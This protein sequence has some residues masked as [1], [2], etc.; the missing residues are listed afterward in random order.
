LRGD[1]DQVY[2]LNLSIG[3]VNEKVAPP[4]FEINASLAIDSTK[5]M[6]SLDDYRGSQKRKMRRPSFE[7]IE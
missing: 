6:V 2:P 4:I 5:A 7:L 3:R 1:S